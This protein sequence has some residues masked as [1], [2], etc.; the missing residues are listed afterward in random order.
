MSST[1]SMSS[2]STST[3]YFRIPDTLKSWPW[4]RRL[5][6]NYTLCKAESATWCESFK[7]F[8]SKGQDAFNR[9]DFSQ[10]L[11]RQFQK[12]SYLTNLN[13]DLDLLAFPNL[14]KGIH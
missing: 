10:W 12:L 7:A 13:F 8:D 11:C 1:V 3:V 4:P 2:N 5:N 9:C 6:P 14:N